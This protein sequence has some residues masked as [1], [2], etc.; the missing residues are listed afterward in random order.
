MATLLQAAAALPVMV[1]K[2][3]KVEKQQSTSGNSASEQAD[4]NSIIAQ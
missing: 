1:S 4:N 3:K 2:F